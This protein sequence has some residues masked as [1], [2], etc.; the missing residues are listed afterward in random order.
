VAVIG[1]L[2][3]SS[4]L[5]SVEIYDPAAGTWSTSTA[6]LATARKF[7]TAT[8]RGTDGRVVIVGGSSSA[9]CG[10]G[11]RGDFLLQQP[12]VERHRER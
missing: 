5:S 11:E 10:A 12:G 6:S 4:T 8:L 2:G 1:G 7:H 9:D 3:A